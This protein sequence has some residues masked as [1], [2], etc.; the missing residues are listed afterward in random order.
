MTDHLNISIN[1]QLRRFIE[2][3]LESGEYQ[4][5]EDVV[6]AGLVTLM[7]NRAYP[8]F[9]PGE[10]ARLID[11]GEKSIA[12]GGLLDADEAYRARQLRKASFEP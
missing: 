9:P 7:Q 3:K 1:S 5:P 2:K 12:N 11:E 6:L 8:D 10:L 4:T